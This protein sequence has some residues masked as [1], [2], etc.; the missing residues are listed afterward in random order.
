MHEIGAGYPKIHRPPLLGE[1][2]RVEES[3]SIL[4]L[5]YTYSTTAGF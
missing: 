2:L 1:E 5:V 4:I 3:G